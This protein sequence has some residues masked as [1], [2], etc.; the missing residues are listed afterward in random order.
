MPEILIP[1]S[2]NAVKR[3]A[4]PAP[5]GPQGLSADSPATDSFARTLQAQMD[6]RRSNERRTQA[7]DGTQRPAERAAGETSGARAP[8]STPA[9]KPDRPSSEKDR[10][11]AAAS[12]TTKAGADSGE[13][14][15]AE[16][17]G[18]ELA[19]ASAPVID[20]AAEDADDGNAAPA[21][22]AAPVAPAVVPET[23][24][25]TT[26]V[27]VPAT[28][29]DK[30]S[31]AS[32]GEDQG[33]SPDLPRRAARP[34]PLA[35]AGA[36]AA[37]AGRADKPAGSAELAMPADEQAHAAPARIRAVVQQRVDA[38]MPS[39]AAD[40]TLSGALARRP[41][42]EGGA[43]MT[44]SGSPAGAAQAGLRQVAT[45]PAPNPTAFIATPAD[46]AGFADELGQRVVLFAG[47][48]ESKAELILTPA[49]LG[50]VEVSLTVSADQATAQFLATSNAAREAL[51]QAM[52]RLREM[53]AEAGIHLG[54]SSVGTRSEQQARE[55][56]RSGG[57][58]RGDVLAG[59]A[60][61]QAA[62]A[63]HWVRQGNGLI[64]TFA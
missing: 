42:V 27:A 56:G 2:A 58:G 39:A 21:Q 8:R 46:Q 7:A 12:T 60:E 55:G 48:G 30:A 47:R 31:Q 62:G 4:E 44:Q 18:D 13:T 45:A 32:A 59:G 50:R 52:P 51:E 37:E 40:S 17:S 64:D 25:T 10:A 36:T 35:Q 3:S 49:H 61:V 15:P 26:A 53:L 33:D 41:G 23:P 14:Q 54:E 5:K 16:D 57:Y 43:D 6:D 22:I 11:T 28:E 38:Q 29:A 63:G 9:E 24:V 34:L 1:A 19:T 20:L